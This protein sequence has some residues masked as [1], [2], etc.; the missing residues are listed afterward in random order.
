MSKSTLNRLKRLEKAID[1]DGGKV[2]VIALDPA[3]ETQQH[4]ISKEE[5]NA[6]ISK[7]P[8]Q[9]SISKFRGGEICINWGDVTCPE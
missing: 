5:H 7:H 4:Y 3:A 2:L 6:E 1:P 9:W 8:E